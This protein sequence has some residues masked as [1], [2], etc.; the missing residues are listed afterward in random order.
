MKVLELGT[1][2][3]EEGGIGETGGVA[4]HVWELTHQLD[5]SGVNVDLFCENYLE[6][7]GRRDLD[8]SV[9]GLSVTAI[10][11]SI[12][13]RKAK[14]ADLRTIVS[15]YAEFGILRVAMMITYYL[16][17]VWV[18]SKVDPDVIHAHHL[19]FRYRAAEIAVGDEIPIVATSHS[20]HSVTDTEGK[21]RDH[22]YSLLE[23]CYSDADN[24]IFVSEKLR[25]SF[26]RFFG[27][28]EGDSRVIHN[29][30]TLKEGGSPPDI[31]G[32]REDATTLLFVG[33]FSERK[34]VFTLVE[35][36]STIDAGEVDLELLIVGSDKTEAI[37]NHI[38]S[39][40]VEEQVL[41]PGR[42]QDVHGYYDLA[43][44]FVLPTQSESFGL[45][46]IEAM[47]HGTPIIGT[48]GVPKTVIPDTDIGYRIDPDDTGEL[49]EHI[50]EA[51][52]R[53]WDEE[54]IKQHAA[55]FNWEQA[56]QE[57][58]QFYRDVT[59]D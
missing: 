21:K 25:Q 40:G 43:D 51:V 14:F 10:I 47:G 48:T 35:A 30:V 12:L 11:L 55:T 19:E 26:N 37:E 31:K 36:I 22:Y 39:C 9:H 4:T 52:E 50:L 41:V 45:V 27:E 8:I 44:L 34:G 18:I 57:Y 3:H 58:I 53:D 23:G 59:E 42:V 6:V 29:P 56:I 13:S 1:L 5:D 32:H 7:T 28:H 16:N 2:P 17:V 46:F 15:E 54:A 49:Q 38:Q 24:L 20:I 33:D